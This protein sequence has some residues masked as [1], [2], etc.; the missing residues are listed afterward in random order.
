M[1][2]EEYYG[3]VRQQTAA[4]NERFP[5]GFCYLCSIANRDR[6]T[7]DGSVT[8]AANDNAARCLVERT[9]RLATDDE[10]AEWHGHQQQNAQASQSK[11][12]ELRGQKVM[13][14]RR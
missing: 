13:W 8:E 14:V 6:G 12:F 7:V 9:H 4:L 3:A 11:E 10:V 5:Q 2:T 1:K